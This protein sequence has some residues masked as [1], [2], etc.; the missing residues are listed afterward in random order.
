MLKDL[1]TNEM[2]HL[3]KKREWIFVVTILFLNFFL[4]AGMGVR[5]CFVFFLAREE[6]A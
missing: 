5:F 4:L 1:R 6:A 3:D 2:I